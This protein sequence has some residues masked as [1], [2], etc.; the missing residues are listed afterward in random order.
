MAM[1]SQGPSRRLDDSVLM[2]LALLV[3]MAVTGVADLAWRLGDWLSGVEQRIPVNPIAAAG[4]LAIGQLRWP[5]TASV[6]TV[7]GE[8]ALLTG[9]SGLG[10]LSSRWK[11]TPRAR[12]DSQAKLMTPARHLGEITGTEAITRAQRLRPTVTISDA[13]DIGI[14]LGRTVIGDTPVIMGWEDVGICFAGPRAGKTA[15]LAIPGLCV[16]PGPAIATSNKRDLR[17]ACRGVREEAGRIWESD[18]QGIT[19]TPHQDWWWNPLARVRS[20]GDARTLAGYFVSAAKEDNA[21]EDAYFS[22]GS[23]ELLAL[24]MWAAASGHGD[25]I[26]TLAWLADP[27][28]AT[29]HRQLVTVR[30]TFAATKLATAQGLNPRQRDGLYDMARRNLD[31]FTDPTAATTVVPPTRTEFAADTTELADWSSSGHRDLPEFEPAAFVTSCDTLFALSMEGP[32][33][34]TGL[35]T[36]LVG[37]VLDEALAVAR[38]SV[39]GRLPTPMV[40]ILDEAANVCKLRDLPKLYSHLGS[41][42]IVVLT[43]LQSPAQGREVWS[44]EALKLLSEQSN[45][46]YYGG[47]IRDHD[48]LADLSALADD[49]DVCHWSRSTG[50]GGSSVSQSWS[51]QPILPVA[52]LAALPKDRAVVWTAGNPPV[53]IRKTSWHTTR[54]ADGIRDSLHRYGS[55]EQDVTDSPDEGRATS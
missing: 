5:V 26:H 12:L 49:Y 27:D 25:L 21:R 47:G 36:A 17:D 11:R 48:Y 54:F 40:A 6:G 1:S 50:P 33:S 51:R 29:A 18:L 15:S 28:D 39:G 41:Q 9:I 22:G 4:M 31:V 23:A 3:V 2:L 43:F 34:A 7:L 13:S 8:A 16:A 10:R 45:V 52:M 46:H 14:E 37:S 44:P 24:Y 32:A 38:A 55:D 42:G 19:G 20:L 35:T 53:L 30:D